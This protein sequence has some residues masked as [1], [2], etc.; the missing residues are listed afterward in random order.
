M[1]FFILLCYLVRLFLEVIIYLM[2]TV[3]HEWIY[4]IS[5]VTKIILLCAWYDLILHMYNYISCS[6]ILLYFMFYYIIIFHVLLYYYISCSIIL[7]YFIQSYIIL[8]IMYLWSN[9]LS[10]SFYHSFIT[11]NN[12]WIHSIF[13][14][15][16]SIGW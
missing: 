1:L 10:N 2:Y 9:Y 7:L 13:I 11:R 5:W 12:S 15:I 8:T 14:Y 3:S 16:F 6:I 4:S